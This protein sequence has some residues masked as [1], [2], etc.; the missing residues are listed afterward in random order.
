MPVGVVMWWVS[1]ETMAERGR[2]G[3]EGLMLETG[4]ISMHVRWCGDV[5]AHYA[6]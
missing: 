3:V 5:V 6:C 1:R 4:R 2:V